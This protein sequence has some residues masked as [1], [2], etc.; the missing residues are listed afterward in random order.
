[1]HKDFVFVG[2]TCLLLLLWLRKQIVYC[3]S[4]E[5]VMRTCEN[6]YRNLFENMAEG[7]VL[8]EIV[9]NEQGQLS[10]VRALEV[11]I[12]FERLTGLNRKEV[13]GRCLLEI[14]GES[15]RIER[16]GH[17]ALTGEPMCFEDYSPFYKR[18]FEIVAYCTKPGECAAMLS[19][20]TKRKNIEKGLQNSEKQ[21][22]AVIR[23]IPDLV[24]VK[25]PHGAYLAC[26][27]RFESFF[28]AQEKDIIGKTDYDFV[29]KTLADF[30]RER[31]QAAIE[32]G[33]PVVN[34]EEI[35]FAS[36]GHREILET[37]KAPIY[38]DKG[39]L[40]GVLGIGRDITKRKKMKAEQERLMTAIEQVG[41]MVVITDP[42]GYIQYVNPAF[43]HTTG[44][45][46]EEVIGQNARIFKSGHHDREFYRNIMVSISSGYT[47]N[48]RMINKCKDGSLITED[49]TISPVY[50]ES[51]Q[52]VNYVSVKRDITELVNL[53][54]RLRQSQKMEAV[55]CLAG[56]VA[57][58]YNNMLS[59]ILGSAQLAMS[60]LSPDDSVQSN[61]KAIYDAGNRSASITRQL[62]AF[63]RKQAIAPKIIDLNETVDGMLKM[64]RRLI[65]EHIDLT[66]SPKVNL[67]Q[68]KMDPSQIDQILMNLCINARDAISDVG[69]IIVETKNVAFDERYCTDHAGFTPGEF[70]LLSVSDNG[71]GIDREVLEHIF[72]PFFTTKEAGRGTG[73][74]LATIY[75]IAKQNM[76]FVNAYSETGM[77]TIIKVYLPRHESS[78]DVVESKIAPILPLSRGETVLLVEDNAMMMEVTSMMLET[79]G[80]R[81]ITAASPNMA[82]N[83]SKEYGGKIDLLITDVVMP[84]M[85]GRE[86]S[87]QIKTLLCPIKILFMSGYTANM[88]AQQGVLEEGVNFIQKPFSMHDLADKVRKAL[89]NGIPNQ[90]K[91]QVPE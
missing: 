83:M 88:I 21:L 20:I 23:A 44:Y 18:W 39:Q 90:N 47:W 37:I 3:R 71:C 79:L 76:G 65:G 64:V 66:W 32:N 77:G 30:F 22:R 58:D 36:D 42:N 15:S 34:E 48:G 10:D 86:L 60:K 19:D 82:L 81:V 70:V 35:S 75:G 57:H 72:E 78:S 29:D 2:I 54:S 67:W 52:I 59:V 63:A 74:G 13:I 33:K 46:R 61:L 43:E 85:N 31:D 50:D 26:N 7:F 80:Y 69:E 89:E 49:V 16:Y 6:N 8:M 28:G 11:N 25:D 14:T 1:M 68:I 4:V 45:Y 84:R 24:W 91:E 17:V 9:T 40:A 38:A 27:S 73:L 5:D 51:H 12:A 56:G 87:E 62:L 41:E 55:G 53:E